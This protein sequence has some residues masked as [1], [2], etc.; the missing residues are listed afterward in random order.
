MTPSHSLPITQALKPTMEPLQLI[1]RTALSCL[2]PGVI[3]IL[4]EISREPKW[5]TFR[6]CDRLWERDSRACPLAH[7]TSG[8]G[9]GGNSSNTEQTL[10]VRP[11][12]STLPLTESHSQPTDS[13][14]IVLFARQRDLRLE[15]GS[16]SLAGAPGL[17][18]SC[19]PPPAPGPFCSAKVGC[20]WE[21]CSKPGRAQERGQ[22]RN[23]GAVASGGP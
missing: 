8:T 9:Y 15:M 11:V 5:C 12:L 22:L 20:C 7:I 21:Q 10:S 3:C 17:K 14:A 4:T 6:P 2:L 16:D 13:R 23:A 1:G 19:C 18:G